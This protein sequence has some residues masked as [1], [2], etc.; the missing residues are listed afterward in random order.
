M[1]KKWMVFTLAVS[2]L[3]IGGYTA[4]QYALNL[5]A[6]QL[7][8]QLLVDT[9]NQTK[10]LKEANID[11]SAVNDV[12][13][14]TNS[15]QPNKDSKTDGEPSKNKPISASNDVQQGADNSKQDSRKQITETQSIK[16]E[17]KR[18]TQATSEEEKKHETTFE[19]KQEAVKFAMS[20]FSA[21]EINHIRQLANGGLT[22][23][24]KAELKKIAYSKFSPQEIE[25]VR[26]AVS[27]K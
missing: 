24:K 12:V 15:D 6:D 4:Y 5:V 8:K 18:S 26:K 7:A 22:P 9:E 1:K 10:L 11:V 2:V 3:G 20:R 14:D 17:D 19:S 23:E 13:L 25:A 16:Q 21:S 27:S